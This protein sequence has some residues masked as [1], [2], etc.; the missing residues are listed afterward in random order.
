[1]P[2]EIL[3]MLC[4]ALATDSLPSSFPPFLPLPFPL[5]KCLDESW[6]MFCFVAVTVIVVFTL[7]LPVTYAVILRQR[8]H[9]L[10]ESR[11]VVRKRCLFL[12]SPLSA[13]LPA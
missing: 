13:Y 6:L 11:F 4:V 9:Q 5:C 10:V 2:H 12:P 3:F 7:G 8:R 1:M